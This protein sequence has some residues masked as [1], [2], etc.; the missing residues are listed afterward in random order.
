MDHSLN[1]EAAGTD[2]ELMAKNMAIEKSKNA[3][4][5]EF[6]A[7]CKQAFTNLDVLMPGNGILH[8]VNIEH[9]SPV[10]YPDAV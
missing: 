8:Q 9:L 6:L 10:R 2:P 7:W 4:R 3:E 1:V 5:F